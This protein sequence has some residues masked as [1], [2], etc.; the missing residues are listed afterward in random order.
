MGYH[1][2]GF[3]CI[4]IDLKEQ[5]RYP[6]D[7]LPFLDLFEIDD[8]NKHFPQA[9][10]FHASP[11]CQLFSVSTT[12]YRNQ[13]KEYPDLLTPLRKKL[14]ATGKPFIIENVL[15]APMRKDLVLCGEMFG[16][17]VIRH[18]IFEIHGLTV[19]QPKHEVHKPPLGGKSYYITV[20]GHGYHSH[21]NRLDEWQKAMGIDWMQKYEL[22]Q[23]I[24]PAYTEYI[25]RQA[26]TQIP[27][28][29]SA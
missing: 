6:F 13:G 21:S 19:L 27:I 29:V 1:R 12:K 5:K 28:E 25:G 11:P 24:P 10:V 7:H 4:G 18:R 14:L 22:T 9:S 15:G 20:V 23:A 16:L 8:L 3:D 2:A 26:I 17:R